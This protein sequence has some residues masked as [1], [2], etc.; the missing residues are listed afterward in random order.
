MGEKTEQNS[1]KLRETQKQERNL[2]RPYPNTSFP[3]LV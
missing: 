2:L 3:D 1:Q